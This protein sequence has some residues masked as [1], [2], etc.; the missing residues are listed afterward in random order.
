[1][2][3]V[4][5]FIFLIKTLC[6]K[7]FFCKDV[8]FVEKNDFA[9]HKKWMIKELIIKEYKSAVNLKFAKANANKNFFFP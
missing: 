7:F 5:Q 2:S 9:R 4:W 3:L 1:M 8:S 6:E